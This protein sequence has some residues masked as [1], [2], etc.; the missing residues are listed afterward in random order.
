MKEA[1]INEID[2][3]MAPHLATNDLALFNSPVKYTIESFKKA[4]IIKES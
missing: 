2:K 4:Y 1:T 3:A